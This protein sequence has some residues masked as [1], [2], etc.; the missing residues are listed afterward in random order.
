MSYYQFQCGYLSSAI[1]ELLDRL[2]SGRFSARDAAWMLSHFEAEFSS[3][4]QQN[5]FPELTAILDNIICRG[6]PTR[7][8]PFLEQALS[9]VLR[10]TRKN[11]QYGGFTYGWRDVSEPYHPF[12][13]RAMCIVEPRFRG[14]DIELLVQ[15]MIPDGGWDDSPAERKFLKEIVPSMLGE[16]V[17]QLAEPQRLLAS[18]LNPSCIR[19]ACQSIN[20]LPNRNDFFR[21]RVDFSFDFPTIVDN[22]NK[23]GQI[24]EI[25]GSTHAKS[26]QKELDVARD[27]AILQKR[28]AD[29]FPTIRIKAGWLNAL[30]IQI[31]TQLLSSVQHPYVDE[32]KKNFNSPFW[33]TAEHSPVSHLV[34]TPFAVAR[35]HKALVV[36][37]QNGALSLDAAE[38]KIAIRERDVPCAWLAIAD[39][40]DMLKNLMSL[41][42]RE[43][44]TKIIVRAYCTEEFKES[45]LGRPLPDSPLG[46]EFNREAVGFGNPDAA[47]IEAFSADVYLDVAVLQRKGWSGL[48]PNLVSR[49]AHSAKT[50]VIR[51]SYST[52]AIR[53]V[54]TAQPI[55][56]A[57]DDEK[58]PQVLEYFLRLI[59]RKTDFRPGQLKIIQKAMAR[60]SIVG[61]LPTGAGKSICYQIAAFLQPGITVIVDPLKSLMQDQ[62][63]NLNAIGVDNTI[64]INSDLGQQDRLHNE[65]KFR[66]RQCQFIFI[67]PERLQIQSFR[68]ILGRIGPVF[69]YVVVDEAHCV[70]EWGHDFRIAYLRVGGN[71]RR[72]CKTENGN[73]PIIALTGTASYDVLSDVQ[74]E[75]EVGERDV[76]APDSFERKNLN[77]EICSVAQPGI[78]RNAGIRDVRNAVAIAKYKATIRTLVTTGQRE[79]IG[80]AQGADAFSGIVFCPHADGCFGV[81]SVA[82]AVAQAQIIP[83]GLIATFTGANLAGG[84]QNTQRAF[85]N[86][87]LSLLVATK[88]F[89]MGID[90]PNIRCTIHLNMPSSI[91]AFYQEAGRAGR[92]GRDAYC[93]LLLLDGEMPHGFSDKSLMESFHDNTFRGVAHEARIIKTEILDKIEWPNGEARQ[94]FRSVLDGMDSLNERPV[95]VP[96]QNASMQTIA[97]RIRANC[98]VHGSFNTELVESA[99]SWAKTYADFK[100]SVEKK[101]RQRGLGNFPPPP[102]GPKGQALSQEI[103]DLFERRRLQDDTDRALYR[104]YTLGIVSDFTVDYNA[105]MVCVMVKKLSP[106]ELVANL[107]QYLARYVSNAT[108]NGLLE[109][110]N[111][112]TNP[113][114]DSCVDCLLEFVYDH[115]A[116]KRKQAIQVMYTTAQ[117]GIDNATEFTDRVN[118]YFSSKF[119]PYLRP[120]ATNYNWEL[121]M[122]YVARVGGNPDN[123][124]HLRGACDR[125][126]T[127]HPENGAFL[128]LHAYSILVRGDQAEE[129]LAIEDFVKG[130]Y[131]FKNEGKMDWTDCATKAETLGCLIVQQ[132]PSEGVKKLVGNAVEALHAAWLAGFNKRFLEG[133]KNA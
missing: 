14:T 46:L 125:L 6:I 67:S 120:H 82:K 80:I 76:V 94:G 39:F 111:L 79:N 99:C 121:V 1:N 107:T 83:N 28:E 128:V 131:R 25:D 118:T 30:P 26:P 13:R 21:Q 29:W 41:Q 130:M 2:D 32:V 19:T 65:Q 56:Y 74:R 18:V 33:Q 119:T 98:P 23:R 116:A 95:E 61:L 103:R 16:H 10:L 11:D 45:P 78:Q 109:K 35:I 36:M 113:T 8:S 123:L 71:S 68:D 24:I 42:G 110:H 5:H 50:C 100:I 96:F 85:K 75:L 64:F 127:E 84:N 59:F 90:K 48:E 101:Y 106:Q 69:S 12:I 3:S 126:L 52:R 9:D 86:D 88:A 102:P 104:L 66:S 53:R 81:D 31:K 62:N 93:T 105:H 124:K 122:M 57:W 40:I 4:P 108:A 114:L 97:E 54:A 37:L 129:E 55:S 27:T 70:S 58:T 15:S 49:V 91:E 7:P 34:L 44:K 72:F 92:D 22:G 43:F 63:D 115:I 112:R 20:N 117:A 38:W 77:F 73:V 132:N 47:N 17:L 89:G 133:L 87:E 60:E 51:S